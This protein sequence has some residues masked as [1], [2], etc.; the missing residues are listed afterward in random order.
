MSMPGDRFVA[1][2][3]RFLSGEI[4]RDEL[5]RQVS[6]QPAPYVP[7][8]D[9][10]RVDLGRSDRTG[11]PEFIYAPGKTVEQISAIAERMVQAGIRNVLATRTE[12]PVYRELALLFPE[13]RY[14]PL[15]RLVIFNPAPFM[16]PVG[17]VGIVTAGTSDLP[18]AEEAEIVCNILGS[19]TTR[20][21]D[22]GVAC[23]A[24][25][26]DAV[27]VIETMN[28]VICVAGMEATLPSVLAGL[29]A[30]P[31]IAVPTSV[32]YGVN[33][34]GFNALCSIL[35]SCA[36]GILA[37]NIDNGIG[38]ATAAHRINL[39]AERHAR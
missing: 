13:A 28:V 39:L 36:P 20:I 30:V 1:L 9:F 2:I 6:R 32:G 29:V 19:K 34:G 16:A 31:I 18:I 7:V 10:A 33:T 25:T 37:V 35:G 8:E 14:H 11:V 38:A 23:L 12:E 21:S 17:N 4:D 22:I 26:L 24:R 15:S 27:P 5:V 3:E